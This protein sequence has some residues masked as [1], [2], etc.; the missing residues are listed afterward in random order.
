MKRDKETGRIIPD[1]RTKSGF[2]TKK[3]ALAYIPILKAEKVISKKDT[4]L[5]SLWQ[6][7]S[8]NKMLKLSKSKQCHY[9]TAYNK[10]SD[11]VG[12]PLSALTINDL[13]DAVNEMS[14]TYYPARDMKVLLTHL[15]KRAMAQ[16]D[17]TVNLAEFIEL[18]E[19]EEKE[20]VPFTEKDLQSLWKD[21]GQGNASTGYV[22]LMI[23]SGMMPGE[24]FKAKK[25]MIDWDKQQIIGCG[26]KTKK[27]K[28]TPIVI[29]DIVV[30]VL[31]DLCGYSPTEFILYMHRDAFY[32]EFRAIL[33]RCKCEPRTPYACRHTTA[34]ALA[35]GNIAKDV[36][37]EVMR[38]AKAS[39]TDRYIHTEI[40]T[41]PMLDAVNTL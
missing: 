39:T 15:Y 26:I 10:L 27:R 18:P 17:V 11:I 13:Q 14:P 5:A 38:H 23:Y 4:T 40:D 22:L 19:L 31:R 1:R 2:P 28:E 30:P 7:Y 12:T 16:Q 29:A 3:E 33:K 24:L 41:A 20:A 34:T 35:A 8:T 21:Y 32:D 36:I 6:G 25:T 9:T 37:K